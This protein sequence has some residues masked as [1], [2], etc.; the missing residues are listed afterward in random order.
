MTRDNWLVLIWVVRK[1]RVASE[2]DAAKGVAKCRGNWYAG[3]LVWEVPGWCDFGTVLASV[4]AWKEA[5][6]KQTNL[7]PFSV[8]WVRHFLNSPT[9]FLFGGE[10]SC[11][12]KVQS[13]L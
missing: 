4:E 9:Y 6:V 11:A 13:L 3:G 5:N 10:S 2:K 12:G 7:N 8:A 1:S